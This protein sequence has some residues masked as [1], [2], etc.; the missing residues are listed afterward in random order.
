MVAAV[1]QLV[2]NSAVA[3]Q[4]DLCVQELEIITKTLKQLQIKF[5]GAAP[6]L[7]TVQHLTALR[8]WP[9]VRPATS[10]SSEESSSGGIEFEM[11]ELQALFPFPASLS[12]RI[13]LTMGD[14][15]R[16]LEPEFGETTSPLA[17]FSWIFDDFWDTSQLLFE[18]DPATLM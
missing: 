16:G 17:D 3:S 2:Y 5:A 10:A 13:E 6:V 8:R 9:R 11:Q 15:L 4:S 18:Q 7:N 1:P 14:G 12:P